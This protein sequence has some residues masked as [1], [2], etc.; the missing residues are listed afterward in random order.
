MPNLVSLSKTQHLPVVF[1]MRS[2]TLLTSLPS[3]LSPLVL[4]ALVILLTSCT[5]EPD[6]PPPV[7]EQTAASLANPSVAS[8]IV[9]SNEIILGKVI[10]ILDGDTFDILD[11]NKKTHRIR[12]HGIDA[13]EKGQPFGRNAREYLAQ[14][15]AGK[16]IE[17]QRFDTDR[18]GRSIGD[19]VIEGNRITVEMIKAGLAW[20]YVQYAPDD[21]ELAIAELEARSNYYGLWADK[22]H[23][24]PWQWRKL[25]KEERDRLR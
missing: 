1:A 18:Y 16:Q 20:H 15:L 14:R 10:A 9:P 2:T 19:V 21:P 25:T 22:R 12:L 8:P 11:S 3:I 24:E 5:H 17:V 7:T 23:V 13:P 6:T 4:L